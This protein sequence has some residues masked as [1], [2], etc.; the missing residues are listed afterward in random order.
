MY[1]IKSETEG[2]VFEC[3]LQFAAYRY[4]Y[5]WP[6]SNVLYAASFVGRP[7]AANALAAGMMSN[8]GRS[9]KITSPESEVSARIDKSL[10]A[11]SDRVGDVLHVIALPQKTIE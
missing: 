2:R 7:S 4:E 9:F 1:L 10:H 11:V 3:A 8:L 6:C 5:K